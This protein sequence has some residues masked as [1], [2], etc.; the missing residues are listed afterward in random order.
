MKEFLKRFIFGEEDDEP[1]KITIITPK[2][3][4]KFKADFNNRED[5]ERAL[6]LIEEEMEIMFD[7]TEILDDDG[8]R[9]VQDGSR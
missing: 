4:M 9:S 6:H 5:F 7:K 2:G 3:R 1:G 8:S